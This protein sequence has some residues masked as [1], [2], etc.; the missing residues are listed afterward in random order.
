[1]ESAALPL[2]LLGVTLASLKS[3]LKSPQLYLSRL[4]PQPFPDSL[5]CGTT[6]IF[7]VISGHMHQ[8]F[9]LCYHNWQLSRHAGLYLSLSHE[10]RWAHTQKGVLVLYEEDS[11]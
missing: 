9:Y 1:M 2:D 8:N 6:Y 11:V 10:G 3:A 4:E 7:F 5:W